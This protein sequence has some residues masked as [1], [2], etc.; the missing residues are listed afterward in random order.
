MMALKAVMLLGGERRPARTGM[1]R[2]RPLGRMGQ[3]PRMLRR[4]RLPADLP[5]GREGQRYR[6]CAGGD[7]CGVISGVSRRVQYKIYCSLNLP[8]SPEFAET[9]R[10]LAYCPRTSAVSRYTV[11]ETPGSPQL[12]LGFAEF[13]CSHTFRT[14]VS[15]RLWYPLRLSRL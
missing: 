14:F 13:R 6:I 10:D 7:T 2:P 1:A 12:C 15:P 3:P 5:V 11:P 9:T 4:R 8:L